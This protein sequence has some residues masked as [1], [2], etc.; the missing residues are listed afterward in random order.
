MAPAIYCHL[1]PYYYQGFGASL[2]WGG[3]GSKNFFQVLSTAPAM[4]PDD[5]AFLPIFSVLWIRIRM[6]PELLP[7]S[8]SGIIDPDPVKF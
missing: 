4:A 3:S 1:K 2:F 8:G 5:I 6:N 7:G